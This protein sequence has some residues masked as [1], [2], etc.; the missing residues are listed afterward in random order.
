MSG[1]SLGYPEGQAVTGPEAEA[2]KRSLPFFFQPFTSIAVPPFQS[3]NAVNVF[4]R[5]RFGASVQSVSLWSEKAEQKVASPVLR[6][7]NH[8]AG[9]HYDGRITA[10]V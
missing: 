9:A 1:P 6:D 3:G 7:R 5:F 4:C 2:S 10:M 8:R